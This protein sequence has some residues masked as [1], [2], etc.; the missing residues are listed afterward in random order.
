[1][2]GGNSKI[3]KVYIKLERAIKSNFLGSCVEP[4]FWAS[5]VFLEDA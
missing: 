3:E 2:G 5:T 4:V 1:M